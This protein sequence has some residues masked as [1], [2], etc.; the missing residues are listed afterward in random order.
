VP[1]I[2]RIHEQHL[3]ELAFL[4][5]QRRLALRSVD[6][7]L[8]QFL[9]LEERVAA[10]LDG[11]VV[12]GESA[13]GML[14]AALEGGDGP[15]AFAAALA[16]LH[17]RGAAAAGA[18][19]DS[20]VAA[21]GERLAGLCGA[22]CHAPAA[23]GF[24][25]VERLMA[26]A[27]GPLAAAAAEVLAFRAPNALR[28]GRQLDRLV[29]H[30]A[31]EV[32]TGAWRVAGLAGLVLQPAAYESAAGDDDRGVRRAAALAAALARA[33][34]LMDRALRAAAKPVARDAEL[35]E[36]AAM[37]AP[38]GTEHHL[39][40]AA[41]AVVPGLAGFRI[42]A[43][44]GHPQGVAVL[45]AG[46]DGADSA[47][48][49]AAGVAFAAITGK[50]VASG[51]RA[52]VVPPDA[53]PDAFEKEFLDEVMLPDAVVARKWW[54]RNEAR[55]L[56]GSR[57]CRGVECSAVAAPGREAD[58]AAHWEAMVRGRFVGAAGADPVGYERF[59]RAGTGD[60]ETR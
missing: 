27:P 8:R 30:E 22:M 25:S 2:R 39:L 43:A 50:S 6:Y 57:W 47:A 28:R 46:M 31:P 52:P 26:E 13:G 20:F 9:D 54:A 4:W 10:H 41:R 60:E 18:V 38:A 44:L 17:V 51:V 37:V 23:V 29:R 58:M 3:E 35:L 24:Q 33:P 34:G 7:S 1:A 11:L 55:F 5:G 14:E 49:S 45:L 53:P 15:T 16:L 36:I 59:P 12:A 21:E 32:R 40:A 19:F 42:L 48:T 56:G